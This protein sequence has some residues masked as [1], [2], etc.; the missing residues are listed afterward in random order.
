M[1]ALQ[2]LSLNKKIKQLIKKGVVFIDPLSTYVGPEVDVNQ[3]SGERVIIYPGC[4]ICGKQ[5]V[6]SAGCKIG[7]NTPV[8]IENCWLGENVKLKG[9]CFVRSVFL[10]GANMGSCAEVREGCLLEEEAS[11][12]HCVG[13]KQTIL[14]VFATLGSLINLCDCLLYGGTSRESGGHS[15]VG[16]GYIHF[17]FTPRGDKAT[18]SLFGNVP[19]GVF[20]NQP[21]IFLGGQGGTAGPFYADF[22]KTVPAGL[23]LRNNYSSVDR[24]KDIVSRNIIYLANLLALEEWYLYVRRPFFEA[25]E[26]GPLIFEGAL[27]VLSLAKQE[28]IKQLKK[29]VETTAFSGNFRAMETIFLSVAQDKEVGKMREEFLYYVDARRKIDDKYI[30]FIQKLPP[31]VSHRGTAWL[32]KIMDV[33]CEKCFSEV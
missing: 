6:I 31:H 13:L 15:E 27:E 3:I 25:Q 22:G 8:T 1:T 18:P 24:L 21:R 5:T 11:G 14:L 28:R 2:Q 17:N 4:R 32:Q 29:L 30:E 16:S 7:Q 19:L 10:D 12:A 33:F 9:G 20:L 26:F 23:I